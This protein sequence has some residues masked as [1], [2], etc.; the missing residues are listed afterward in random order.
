MNNSLSN[1]DAELMNAKAEMERSFQLNNDI[2]VIDKENLQ[3]DIEKG[4]Q[5]VDELRKIGFD[6]IVMS[7]LRLP[8]LLSTD[9]SRPKM[10]MRSDD[11]TP[12]QRVKLRMRKPAKEI[13]RQTEV[14]G[15]EAEETEDIYIDN[16][17]PRSP[18]ATPKPTSSPEIEK[19]VQEF[20]TLAKIQ[21]LVVRSSKENKIK[22][23]PVVIKEKMQD[24]PKVYKLLLLQ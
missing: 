3:K 5:A 22:I 1:M 17:K 8:G 21:G 2:H 19:W 11:I 14:P 18:D 16:S 12:P 6:K 9:N 4:M 15:K 10:R 24:A 13:D 23:L 20:T 7:A